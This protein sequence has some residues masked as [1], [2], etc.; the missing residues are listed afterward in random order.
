MCHSTSQIVVERQLNKFMNEYQEGKHEASVITTQTIESLSMNEK[1]MWRTIRKELEDIGISVTAFDAN[2]DF[3]MDWFKV[4]IS[5]GAFEEQAPE[6]DSSSILCRDD[7]YQCLEDPKYTTQRFSQPGTRSSAF[8]DSNQLETQSPPTKILQNSMPPA[9]N[10]SSKDIAKATPQLPQHSP[11]QRRRTP[12]VATL[13]A[14]ILRYN[15]SLLEAAKRG[16]EVTVQKLLLEK[17]ADAETEDGVGR[18]PLS[19]AA[20]NGHEA[21]VNLLLEKGA[22]ANTRDILFWTPL[23]LAAAN[24]HKA[25]VKLLLEKGADAETKDIYGQTPLSRAAGNGHEAV[26]KLLL[27][28]G[29]DAETKDKDNWTPLSRAAAIGYEAVVKL[30]LEKGADAET[31]DIY[32]QTPLSRAAGNG[33]EAVVKLLLEKGADAETKDKD[34]RTPLSWAAGNGHE[35]VVKLLLE[36]GAD[37]E[38]KDIYG[39]TPLSWAAGNGHEAVVKLL[40]EKGADAETKD[41]YGRTPLSWAAGSGHEAVVKLLHG[42]VVK[43]LKVTVGS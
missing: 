2:K 28:K 12:R 11:T 18:R 14:W 43:L 36:K 22:R 30:L 3:I 26:V 23:S 24:G 6:D 19:W 32:G 29:A 13:V 40:L 15:K 37:A 34:N 7:V 27:E 21:V 17:G 20:W 4:A 41:T 8:L 35:A 39:R 16:D 1:Q 5:N 31:K 38:T 42:A 10:L 25:V 9:L 33:Y